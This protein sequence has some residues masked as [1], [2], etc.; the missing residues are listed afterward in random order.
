M[1][2]GRPVPE[3]HLCQRVSSRTLPVTLSPSG[4]KPLEDPLGE[5]PRRNMGPDRSYP[6]L[7]T[8][9]CFWKHYLPLRSVINNW[10]DWDT[11][12]I[13][14]YPITAPWSR[15]THRLKLPKISCSKNYRTPPFNILPLKEPNINQELTHVTMGADIT[16]YGLNIYVEPTSQHVIPLQIAIIITFGTKLS[17]AVSYV[18]YVSGTIQIFLCPVAYFIELINDLIGRNGDIF[19]FCALH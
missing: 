16:P 2:F 1:A 19:T 9:R 18:T 13:Y 15:P 17:L 7:W 8:D 3:G 6:R 5:T 12:V 11:I 10:Y 14:T 4:R